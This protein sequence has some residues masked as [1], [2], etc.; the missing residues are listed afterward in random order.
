MGGPKPRETLSN[1]DY[2]EVEPSA[3]PGANG[4]LLLNLIGTCILSTTA[5]G[6]ISLNFTF[7]YFSYLG[8]RDGNIHL[9]FFIR[10]ISPATSLNYL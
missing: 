5:V 9:L 7:P 2:E 8:H 6:V 3:L 4:F 1:G 10:R